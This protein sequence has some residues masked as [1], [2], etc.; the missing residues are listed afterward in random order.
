M[1]LKKDYT[2]VMDKIIAWCKANNSEDNIKL[3]LK[4]ELYKI[5]E[6]GF[7]SGQLNV[8]NDQLEG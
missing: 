2:E 1:K 7:C 8:L 6:D 3:V 5:Y 4:E